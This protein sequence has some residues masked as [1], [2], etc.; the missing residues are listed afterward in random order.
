MSGERPRLLLLYAPGALGPVE[1]L[2]LLRPVVDLVVAVPEEFRDDPGVAMLRHFLEPVIFDPQG[3]LPDASGCDG[4]VSFTDLLARTAAQLTHRYGLPGQSP[5]AALALTDKE[6]QRRVL[7]EHGVDTLRT[8]TLYQPQDWEPAVAHTGL[9]AVLKPR[10]GAGSRNSYRIDDADEGARLVERLLG[11]EEAVMVLE[12]MLVGV[13]QGRHGD[14]CSV[15]SAT[16]D[17]VTTHLPVLSKYPLVQPFRERGQFWPS[18]L[19]EATQQRAC[20]VTTAALRALGFR[21]GLSHTELKLTADGP[22]VIEVNSR[23]GGWMNELSAH[24]NGPDLIVAAARLALGERP[25]LE[26]DLGSRVVF[27]FNHLAPP[28]AVAMLGAEGLAEVRALDGV[29]AHRVLFAPG[30]GMTPGVSTQELDMLNATAADQDEMYALIG[31]VSARLR[32]G[33]R[34]RDGSEVWLPATELPSAMPAGRPR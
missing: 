12:E 28:D 3:E 33:F 15:E 25:D 1:M 30:A 13:D 10:T 18:H 9:P 4:V 20:E 16:F 34:L 24:S 8:A 32:F 21:Y 22:R 26:F 27:Q 19:D 31:A 23:L 11:R 5:E 17:G 14:F 7:A 29:I 6:V 2:R